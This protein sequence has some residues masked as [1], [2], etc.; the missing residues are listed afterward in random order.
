MKQRCKRVKQLKTQIKQER[1]IHIPVQFDFHLT[2]TPEQLDH[3]INRA[4]NEG[5]GDWGLIEEARVKHRKQACSHHKHHA[6][7]ANHAQSKV[8]L[9]RYTFPIKVIDIEEN[10][11]YT[12]KMENILWALM[13]TIIDFPYA[14]DTTAGYN[15]DV[16]KLTIE[17]IDEIIQ[18]AVNRQLKYNFT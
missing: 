13:I 14:L 5:I 4:I 6:K 10:I 7:N 17:D 16:D 12:L 9:D 3:L 15:L 1:F 11:T 2:I 8:Y 18:V